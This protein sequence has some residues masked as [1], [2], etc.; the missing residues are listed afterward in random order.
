MSAEERKRLQ[1]EQAKNGVHQRNLASAGGMPFSQDGNLASRYLKTLSDT[2]LSQGT[3]TVLDNLLT[4]DF[5]LGNVTDAEYN[6][7]KWLTRLTSRKVFAMHPRHDSALVGERRAFLLDDPDET[8]EPLTEQ[9]KITIENFIRGVFMRAS[10]ARDGWQQEQM[11][12]T[13][14]VSE[15]RDEDDNDDKLMKGLFS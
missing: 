7:L 10:R 13:Y 9:E 8:L 12:K 3:I 1:K 15:I 6:E 2:T 11:S 14:T 4:Q 5:V